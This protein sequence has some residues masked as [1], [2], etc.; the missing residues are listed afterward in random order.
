MHGEHAHYA[1]INLPVPGKGKY[2][3]KKHEEGQ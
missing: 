1:V 2:I 3:K